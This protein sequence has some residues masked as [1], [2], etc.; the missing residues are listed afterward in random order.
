MTFE[1]LHPRETWECVATTDDREKRAMQSA[2]TKM[3]FHLHFSSLDH[4]HTC[5]RWRRLT[6]SNTQDFQR[7]KH[8]YSFNL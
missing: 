5:P 1:R 8:L 7:N 3:A 6:S 4:I 2:G